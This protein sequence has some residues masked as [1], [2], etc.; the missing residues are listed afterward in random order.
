MKRFY[1]NASA[2][3]AENG[4]AVLLDGKTV[5]TPAGQ[6][7]TVPG[8]ALA[9][10]IAA[11]WQVQEDVIV[12]RSM[13]LMRLSATCI[14]H[15]PQQ[16]GAMH[17]RLLAYI[18]T[19]LLCLRA[20]D[21]PEL[22]KLQEAEWQPSLDWLKQAHGIEL[23]TGNGLTV[24]HQPAGATEAFDRK[25]KAFSP[26]VFMGVHEA[27]ACSGSLVLALALQEGVIDADRVFELAELESL[28][29]FQRWGHDMVAETRHVAIRAELN[30]L[31][32]WFQFV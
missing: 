11:E 24:P 29:Q 31:A 32:R 8:Q 22:R 17:E 23:K 26:W 9:E 14:D 21:P 19:D 13:P 30:S 6:L 28:F 18:D 27:A 7:L 5:R 15:V 10:A 12:P 2:E 20:E 4:F 25:L 1:K 16:R 3:K